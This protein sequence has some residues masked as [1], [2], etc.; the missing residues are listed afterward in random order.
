MYGGT[1]MRIVDCHVHMHGEVDA[2]AALRAL[3]A[4][5]VDRMLVISEQ[6]R[7]SLPATRAKLLRTSRLLAAAPD[8][9]AGLA[10]IDPRMPGA[11]G[12]ARDALGDMGFAG[13][14]IIPDHF[15]VYEERLAPF[16]ETLNAL[17]ASVLFHTGILWGN[18]DGSRFCRPVDLEVLLHYPHIRFAMAHISWPW[19][20]E[21]LAVVG[22]MRAAVHGTGVPLQSYIDLTP[23][24][25]AYIRKQALA[26]A[27]SYCGAERP[28]FGSDASLPGDLAYQKSVLE[29][30][31]ELFTELGLTEAEQ[32]RI[33]SGTADELFPPRR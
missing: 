29:G 28:L 9:L 19:C 4:N 8:R 13:I 17:K 25:P 18:D 26:N 32:E 2:E 5:G 33:L 6:E 27:L 31:R 3:D 23:G 12:L 16:W 20:D 21:C 15:H 11:G 30:D 24:T 14:K 1:K 10:W 22:R 7:A